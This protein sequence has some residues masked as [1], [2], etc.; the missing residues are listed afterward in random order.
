MILNNLFSSD[1]LLLIP[2]FFLLVTIL[3][4]VVYSV[5]LSNR[6]FSLFL[7]EDVVLKVS[8]SLLLFIPLLYNQVSSS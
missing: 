5:F 4:I 3:S 1:L 6:S 8:F 2:S 7:V